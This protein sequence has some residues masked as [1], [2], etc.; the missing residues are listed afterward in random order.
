M[1]TNQHFKNACRGVYLSAIFGLTTSLSLAETLSLEQAL[2]RAEASNPGLDAFRERHL[3]ASERIKLASALPDPKLQVAY[4]GESVQTRTGPQDAIYSF[5][6]A[7]PWLEKLG[8]RKALATSDAEVMSLMYQQA[9]LDLRREVSSTY[10]ETAYLQKAVQ[11]TEANL[12]LIKDMQA[13]VEERVRGG[14]SVNAL[15][16]LEVELERTRDQLEKLGQ[17]R[18]TQRNRLAALLSMDEASLGGLELVAEQGALVSAPKILQTVLSTQSPELL[19]LRQRTASAVD[20]VKLSRLERYPDFTFGLNYIQVGDNGA[21]TADAGKDPWSVSVAVNLPIWEGKN[22][23]SI[24]A[25]NAQKRAVEQTYLNRELQIK[26]ALSTAQAALGD[27]QRRMQRYRE[28]LIPLAQQALENSSS[29]Y[30]S[31]QLSVLELIDSERALL[32]LN[33]NYWRAAANVQH[34]IATINALTG[35]IN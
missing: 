1:N 15:L 8:T 6:Q 20:Q 19:A 25:A 26:A 16:R 5:N 9:R 18:V 17:A 14:A 21:M 33:L 4:F 35:Q 3:S 11:S 23:A 7:V 28:K 12:K 24:R 10:A 34:S 31:G 13:I 30:E 22:R 32:D 27:S 29:A 2:Q